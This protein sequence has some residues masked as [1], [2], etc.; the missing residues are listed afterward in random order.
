ML[1]KVFVLGEGR[2]LTVDMQDTQCVLVFSF[3]RIHRRQTQ[4]HVGE[5]TNRS[6]H[7]FGIFAD[8]GA[9]VPD[10]LGRFTVEQLAGP[11]LDVTDLQPYSTGPDAIFLS[12]LVDATLAYAFE[13]DFPLKRYNPYAAS[14]VHK[15]KEQ[16]E[17]TAVN[18]LPESKGS[19][20]PVDLQESRELDSV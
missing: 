18:N 17:V 1:I 9:N 12:D 11:L 19:E 7:N 13:A 4:G 2:S 20:C 8:H 3:K 15:M 5:T 10:A 14:V 6:L 16:E